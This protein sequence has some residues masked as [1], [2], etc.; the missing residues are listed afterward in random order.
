[1]FRCAPCDCDEKSEMLQ[2]VQRDRTRRTAVDIAETMAA[3][4]VDKFLDYVKEV[5]PDT[6]T[7]HDLLKL[8]RRP[9]T[10]PPVSRRFLFP[11][12]PWRICQRH[13]PLF[14]CASIGISRRV[15]ENDLGLARGGHFGWIFRICASTA[16]LCYLDKLPIRTPRRDYILAI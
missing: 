13:D 8:G 15:R 7:A 9:T 16:Y 3:E 14:F 10:V 5:F 4:G 1:M 6:C 2:L 11:H 12:C